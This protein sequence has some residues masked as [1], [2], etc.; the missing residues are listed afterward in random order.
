MVDPSTSAAYG[1][2]RSGNNIFVMS[3]S[4][5]TLIIVLIL[6]LLA[7]SGFYIYE[8]YFK[9]PSEPSPFDWHSLIVFEIKDKNLTKD[10][11]E[12]YQEKFEEVKSRLERNQDD[13]SAWLSL[14]MVRKSV[15]D[16]EGAEA[17]WLYTAKIRPQSSTPYGNL[18][19]LYANFLNQPQKAEENYKKAL[20]L[21]DKDINLYLGLAELY[22]YRLLGK[23]AMYEEVI[24]DALKILP[25]DVNLI[26]PL[27]LYFRQTNQVDK[28]IEYYEKLVLL[29]PDNEMAKEDLEELKKK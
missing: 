5:K 10:A 21:D 25:D 11:I 29:A 23:E 9:K 24:L 28:A 4:K 26:A 19:D 13:F 15:G 2:L 1:G 3:K 20:A 16:Y 22:R 18:A 27:A 14:G 12:K 17:V 7:G 8:K 6:F